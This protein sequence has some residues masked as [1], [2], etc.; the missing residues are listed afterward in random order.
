MIAPQQR[1]AEQ[2]IIVRTNADSSIAY[3]I[4]PVTEVLLVETK[5]ARTTATIIPMTIPRSSIKR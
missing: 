4:L 1:R 3:S 2:R 5:F